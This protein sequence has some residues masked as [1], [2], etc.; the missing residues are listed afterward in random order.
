[1]NY[2]L[3]STARFLRENIKPRSCRIDLGIARSI[4]EDLGLIFS[5]K[6]LALG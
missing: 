5:R 1:M 2:L 3:T 4:R 6:D